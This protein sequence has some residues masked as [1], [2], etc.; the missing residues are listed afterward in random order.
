MYRVGRTGEVWDWPDWA[1]ANSDRTFGN[2]FDDYEGLFRVLYVASDTYGCYLETLARF[3]PDLTFYA[4]LAK[5]E[6]DI[7]HAVPGVIDAEWRENRRIGRAAVGGNYADIGASGW[8][9]A[10]RK[11]LASEALQAGFNDFNAH[12][13]FATAPRSLTQ[14]ISRMVFDNCFDG[15]RYRSKFGLEAVCWALFE[16]RVVIRDH[17]EGEI[18]LNDPSLQ[19]AKDVHGL[20]F[21][22]EIAKKDAGSSC[23]SSTC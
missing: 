16:M 17:S 3:R 6:G 1:R 13:L 19:K 15:I 2:R 14:H 8:L 20:A 9:S 18:V 10:F 22:D 5:I 23:Q 12:A 4:D 7:D 21:Q 11:H